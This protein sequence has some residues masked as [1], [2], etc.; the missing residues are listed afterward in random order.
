MVD[1]GMIQGAWASSRPVEIG[2]IKPEPGTYKCTIRS[3]EPSVKDTRR[4]AMACVR[5]T[6]EIAEGDRAGCVFERTDWLDGDKACARLKGNMKLLRLD[7]P[8]SP[9][10]LD[11]ALSAA[12]G[13]DV[14]VDVTRS[15]EYTNIYIKGVLATQQAKA[16]AEQAQIHGSE[17]T[18][19][20][21]CDID[22][23]NGYLY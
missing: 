13:A 20:Q 16:V 12:S 1:F 3:A 2:R 19:Q 11:M 23:F 8:E 10:D 21:Y 5:W 14:V 7:I 4:G 9:N 17:E 15:G 6:F 22:D 18:A